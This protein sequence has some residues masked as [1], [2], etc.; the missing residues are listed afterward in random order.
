MKST[1]ICGLIVINVLLLAVLASRHMK[2][3]VAEAQARRAGEYLMMPAD[4][5]GARAG[6]VIV[7]DSTTG[8]LSAIMTD[9]TTGKM[10]G[11]PIIK[12]GDIFDRK[13]STG[14]RRGNGAR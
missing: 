7:F 1:L 5:S 8:E 13:S 4:F 12:M 14:T 2:P 3:N 10:Q 9:E 6:A 11:M